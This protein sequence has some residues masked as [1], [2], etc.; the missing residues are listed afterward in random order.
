MFLV[1][2]IFIF[3]ELTP[4][5]ESKYLVPDLLQNPIGGYRKLNGYLSIQPF[6]MTSDKAYNKCIGRDPFEPI[7]LY[8]LTGNLYLRLLDDALIESSRLSKTLLKPEWIAANLTLPISLK[9]RMET[10]GIGF[11]GSYGITDNWFIMIQSAA[12]HSHQ[13]LNLK[14]EQENPSYPLNESFVKD[15]YELHQKYS[16]ILNSPKSQLFN[17]TSRFNNSTNLFSSQTSLSDTIL[18]L[19]YENAYDY[20]NRLKRCK[21]SIFGGLLLPTGHKKNQSE[22]ADINLGSNGHLGGF[23]G[24]EADIVLKEDVVINFLGKINCFASKKSFQKLSV[25]DEPLIYGAWKGFVDISP[26]LSWYFNPSLTL[27]GLRSGLGFKIGYSIAH[28]E[29]DKWNICKNSININIDVS[30][31]ENYSS[32]T[33]EHFILSIFY[34]FMRDNMDHIFEPFIGFVTH[35]PVDWF[36]AEQAGRTCGLSCIIETIY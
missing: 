13:I 28:H 25:R 35:I 6:I 2:L 34:D 26:G 12:M 27:E 17:E 15:I 11:S 22:L 3:I 16:T 29:K 8:E 4:W 21:W 14:P 31:A 36:F 9:G 19:K 7:G 1:V 20:W 10:T 30:R 32:W 33:Q 23:L 24:A 5:I 18:S